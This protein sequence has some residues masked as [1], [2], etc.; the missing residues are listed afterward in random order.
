MLFVFVSIVRGNVPEGGMHFLH[1]AQLWMRLNNNF[2]FDCVKTLPVATSFL[3]ILILLN[4]CSC[5]DSM[6]MYLF[7][8]YSIIYSRRIDSSCAYQLKKK[9]CGRESCESVTIC[10]TFIYSLCFVTDRKKWFKTTTTT[11]TVMSASSRTFITIIQTLIAYLTLWVTFLGSF[12]SKDSRDLQ[13]TDI[14]FGSG[15]T[16]KKRPILVVFRAQC[17]HCHQYNLLLSNCL[18]CEQ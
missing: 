15:T 11:T 18:L 13:R 9:K 1:I 2:D 16:I 17:A 10:M 8:V 14:N 12:F 4:H 6:S 3:S 7:L 5:L